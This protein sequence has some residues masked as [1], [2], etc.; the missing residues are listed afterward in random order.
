MLKKRGVKGKT[1]FY[2]MV[3][4]HTPKA[5]KVIVDLLEHKNENVRLGAAKVIMNKVIPDLKA[6]EMKV[7]GKVVV[8]LVLHVPK[9]NERRLDTT[10]Q[11]K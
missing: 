9:K 1:N 8:G 2:A 3:S 6:T 7:E 10:P 5:L 4:K 11:T